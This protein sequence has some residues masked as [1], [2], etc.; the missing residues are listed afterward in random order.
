MLTAARIE[1][2]RISY[3]TAPRQRAV[4]V[5]REVL[6]VQAAEVAEML[7]SSEASVNSALQRARATLDARLPPAGRELVPG[8][9]SPRERRLVDR[10]VEAFQNDDID[11]VVALLTDDAL[12]TMPPE[13]LEYQGRD[14]VGGFL[15]DRAHARAP[16]ALRLIP[17]RANGQP[18]FGFYIEDRHAAFFRCYGLLVLT[19]A[20]ERISTITRF[21]DSAVLALF[22]MPRTLQR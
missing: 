22:G 17:T 15:L 11:G 9:R 16:G 7:K 5:L 19:L 2:D 10:F 20:G 13:P 21:R 1:V 3:P 18:A 4:L 6:A 12:L 8:A 14:A